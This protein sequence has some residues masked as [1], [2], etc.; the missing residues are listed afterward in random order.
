MNRRSSRIITRCCTNLYKDWYR[1]LDTRFRCRR[2]CRMNQSTHHKKVLA[3]IVGMLILW[4]MI[5]GATASGLMS[6]PAFLSITP[7]NDVNT[8][9]VHISNLSGTGFQPGATVKLTRA[10]APD[11]FATE[12]TV[13][14]EIQ[15]TCTFDIAG[16]LDGAWDIVVTNTDGQSGILKDG[17]IVT[18][19]ALP[20]HPVT[21]LPPPAT[22]IVS[23]SGRWGLPFS[24]TNLTG[25]GLVF[26]ATPTPAA[27]NASGLDGVHGTITPGGVTTVNYGGSQLYTITPDTGYHVADILINGES[28]GAVTSYT[29]TNV[30]ANH[31]IQALFEINTY[32]IT[33]SS[34]YGGSISPPGPVTLNH[35]G[36]QAVTITP[37]TGYH[38]ADVALDGVS[39]GSITD[40]MFTSVQASH[41]IAASFAIKRYT[42]TAGAG[43]GGT[44]EPSGAVQATYGSS[45]MFTIIPDDGYHIATVTVDGNLVNISPWYTFPDVQVSHTISATFAPDPVISAINPDTGQ[46]RKTRP[47]TITGTGFSTT[48]TT[49]VALYYPGTS[50]VF[51]NGESIQVRSSAHGLTLVTGQFDLPASP[52][53]RF[54]DV[55]VTN[56]DG[57]FTLLPNG[58]EVT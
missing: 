28:V 26:G 54:Y 24:I 46:N 42:I 20:A 39:Q 34:G 14:S 38:I 9:S 35:G 23:M 8:T 1:G 22:S 45:L 51:V 55:S 19:P 50:T 29:F 32:T 6:P 33:A 56:P 13:V 12:V 5:A 52:S 3:L 17:F 30:H 31:V 49:S 15:I 57:S 4:G 7:D 36:T 2:L 47:F 27:T 18:S 58:F 48:G 53:H 44:I 21:T 11:I 41:T 10:G 37:D 25:T 16:A 40:Y 43:N